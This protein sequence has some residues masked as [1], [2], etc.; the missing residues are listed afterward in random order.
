MTQRQ[1]WLDALQEHEREVER[2]RRA[3]LALD[4]DPEHSPA[5]PA[6]EDRM[7]REIVYTAQMIRHEISMALLSSRLAS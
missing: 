1:A 7:R 4:A 6:G 3:M 2:L 5:S